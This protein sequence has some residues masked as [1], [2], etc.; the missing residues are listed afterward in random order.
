MT[1][2]KRILKI[3]GSDHIS[4]LQSAF[5]KAYPFLRIEFYKETIP[6][7]FKGQKYLSNT[8]PLAEAGLTHS[9]RMSI[10]DLTTVDEFEN[11]LNNSFGLKIHTF[12]KSGT[13]WL[14]ITKTGNWT[15]QRQNQE[16]KELT[17]PVKVEDIEKKEAPDNSLE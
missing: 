2:N 17:D 8:L 1:Q 13:M 5:N 6:K 9:G 4:D 15:L 3:S 16:G 14:E 10:N 7:V 11:K 12:R